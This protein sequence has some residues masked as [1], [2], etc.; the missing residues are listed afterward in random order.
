MIPAESETWLY[1][2]G[3]S[4]RVEASFGAH[5]LVLLP[6]Q[7]DSRYPDLDVALG[8]S[9]VL[10]RGVRIKALASVRSRAGCSPVTDSCFQGTGSWDCFKGN[11][12][13]STPKW[14]AQQNRR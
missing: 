3:A 4:M 8:T 2:L 6:G 9:E 12:K 10:G 5:P 13:E 14:G 1:C 11:Q 7:L